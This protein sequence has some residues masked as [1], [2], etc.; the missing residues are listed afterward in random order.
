MLTAMTKKAI[1]AHF[2]FPESTQQLE[3]KVFRT[4]VSLTAVQKLESK[5]T[6]KRFLTW[7]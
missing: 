3:M 2:G 1:S 4:L 5:S 7:Q 6:E